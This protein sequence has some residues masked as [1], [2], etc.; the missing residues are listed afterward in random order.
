MFLR[1]YAGNNLDGQSFCA[2]KEIYCAG[3][4]VVIEG[5]SVRVLVG[6]W[7]TDVLGKPGQDLNIEAVES[8]D[9]NGLN[10]KWS[11]IVKLQQTN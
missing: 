1:F 7:C 3:S 9:L 2:C 11:M 6:D 10:C 8:S 5:K 4:S